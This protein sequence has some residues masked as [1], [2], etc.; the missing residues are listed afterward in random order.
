ML[1]A[2]GKVLPSDTKCFKF[3]IH[4]D[5][6]VQTAIFTRACL[7]LLSV[8]T[9]KLNGNLLHKF[10]THIIILSDVFPYNMFTEITTS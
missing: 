7:I 5:R 4:S 9:N 2:Q 3:L 8:V 1:C 10:R 6:F